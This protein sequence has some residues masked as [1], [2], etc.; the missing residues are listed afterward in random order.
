MYG[1]EEAIQAQDSCT[2]SDRVPIWICLY[3]GL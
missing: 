2:A 3:D 1:I